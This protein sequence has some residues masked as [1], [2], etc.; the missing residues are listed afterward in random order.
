MSINPAVL[1][2][3][4]VLTTAAAVVVLSA[5]NTRSIIKRAVA[6]NTTA[7]AIT[8]TVYRLPFGGTALL[9]VP[10][11]SIAANGTDLLPELTTMVLYAGD[12]I[13][14]LASAATS[15]NFF[16]SGYTA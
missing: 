11:R 2:P 9:I 16:A 3:G 7:G 12:G 6:A 14:A 4:I 5:L 1:Q 15:L 8:I 10:P 13:T